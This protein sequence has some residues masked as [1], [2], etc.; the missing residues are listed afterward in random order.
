MG[1][2]SRGS[3]VQIDPEGLGLV[4]GRYAGISAWRSAG[5]LVALGAALVGVVIL[6][7]G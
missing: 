6:L 2:S 7:G 1:G 3:T 4:M 5:V